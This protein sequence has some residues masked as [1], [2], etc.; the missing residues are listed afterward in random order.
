MLISVL[1]F[2]R[3]AFHTLVCVIFCDFLGE[4]GNGGCLESNVSE[5]QSGAIVGGRSLVKC[6]SRY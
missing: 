6:V 1:I 2:V 3:W 5:I 4:Y